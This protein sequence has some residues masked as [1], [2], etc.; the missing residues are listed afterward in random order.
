MKEIELFRLRFCIW[1]YI[2][3]T[4]KKSAAEKHSRIRSLE[5]ISGT[6][7]FKQ[8]EKFTIFLII[9]FENIFC[10]QV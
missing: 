10:I 1:V 3:F 8:F 4:C 5:T 7:I 2:A 6:T 9:A